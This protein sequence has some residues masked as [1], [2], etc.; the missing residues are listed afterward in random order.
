VYTPDDLARMD[1]LRDLGF[2]GEF[3]F[4]RGVYPG[5]YRKAPWQMRLYAGF[6][7]AEDT[8]RRWKFLLQSGNM[9]VSCAF[10]LPTQ[11]G[12]DSDDSL[13]QGE[14]GKVGVA[15]DTLR[16]VEILYDGLPLEKI[17]SSFNINTP[18]A[19][20]LAMYLALAEKQG[21]VLSSL[22]GTLANDM[23]CEYI[24]RGTWVFPPGPA[25]RLSTD[26]V[27]FCTHYLPRFYPYNIRGIIIREAGANM[28]Q[29]G[30]YAFANAIAYIEEALKRRLMIDDFAPRLSFFFSTGLQ[31][32][33]EAARYRA[34]RRLWARMM[35]ER[36]GAKNPNSMLL[37]FTGTVGGSTYRAREP[38]NNLVRGSYGL[39]ANILGGAQGM[40]QPAMDE[41]HAIPTEHTARL[42][43]RTQQI[44]AYETGVTKV[45][46][47]LGGSYFVEAMT[48]KLEE[49]ILAEI[50]KVEDLGGA[51][52]AIEIGYPQ[53]AVAEEAY[54]VAKEEERG[55][56]IV[57]G[58]NK[59]V[60]A[61][62][63]PRLVLH[64]S[65]A[66]T[67]ERQIQRTREVKASRD[68]KKVQKTLDNI[69]RA[70]ETPENLMPYFI[71]AVKAYASIGE[72]T[73]ALK[74]V[75]GEFREPV[76][77]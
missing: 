18:A 52:R 6:G 39:L 7:T 38:E 51:V 62:D 71:E 43:L 5:M 4:T 9:G 57:V 16:D 30:A 54:R 17:T 35:K 33:E 77:I 61:G 59:F 13:A 45:V 70:A 49:E 2:P 56:R 63:S 64:R 23:L 55:E 31:I 46:D 24:S 42:A 37:R 11:I 58:V 15:I 75:F 25:L 10:D 76:N 47:P 28:V 3:P 67:V 32:F 14:V 73:A 40:L 12:L 27:E 29:E 26:I 8:N 1:Y 50:K 34:L 48:N 21:V 41:A 68:G 66:Q 72:I 60:S 22:S 65:D 44:L 53:K 69:C 20:L 19:A 36:F 74:K